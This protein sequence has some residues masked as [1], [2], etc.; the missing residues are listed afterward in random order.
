MV[1]QINKWNEERQLNATEKEFYIGVKNDLLQDKA[2]IKTVL[3]LA[4][5]KD[6]I[7]S[8]L[9]KD[10][11]VLY[12]SDRPKLDSLLKIYFASQRTFY[13]I[14]GTFQAAVSSNDINKFKNKSN[15]LAVTKLY[16]ST[17]TRLLDNGLDTDNRWF[18][19]VKKYSRIRRSGHFDNKTDQEKEEFLDD[20]FFHIYGL[21]HY[22]NNLIS[23]IDEID[24][25][26]AQL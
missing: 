2:Y 4:K 14:S 20:M 18:F 12:D 22:S 11:F 3:S 8:I 17:Y 19:V 15:K 13:P 5:K 21:D 16:N 10:F 25:L 7:Y 1:L 6:S 24:S 9:N 23:T 26:I